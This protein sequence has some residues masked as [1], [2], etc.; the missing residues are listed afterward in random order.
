MTNLIEDV[1]F[2]NPNNNKNW[3][4]V[5]GQT[6]NKDNSYFGQLDPNWRRNAQKIIDEQKEEMIRL[7]NE[8]NSD[9]LPK[10]AIY[11]GS[12]ILVLTLILL[13]YKYK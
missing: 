6:L 4:N 12:G 10:E 7:E 8:V 1:G 3:S 11:L 2:S 9:S 13:I 5:E